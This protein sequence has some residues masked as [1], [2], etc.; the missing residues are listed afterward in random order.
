MAAAKKSSA[1]PKGKAKTGR[2]KPL[3]HT[4]GLTKTKRRFGC[5]GALSKKKSS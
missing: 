1:A 5:G 2:A 3:V 4:P